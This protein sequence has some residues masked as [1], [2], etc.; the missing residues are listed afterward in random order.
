MNRI[1]ENIFLLLARKLKYN[2]NKDMQTLFI[3]ILLFHFVSDK[4]KKSLSLIL[5]TDSLSFEIAWGM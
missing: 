5:M 2:A 1:I 4:S 3:F